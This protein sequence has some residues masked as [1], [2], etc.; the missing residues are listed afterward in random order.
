MMADSSQPWLSKRTGEL[1][2]TALNNFK[3]VVPSLPS[4]NPDSDC[5]FWEP[6][7]KVDSSQQRIRYL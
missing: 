4:P 1:C 5:L 2:F 3:Q 6:N 7:S